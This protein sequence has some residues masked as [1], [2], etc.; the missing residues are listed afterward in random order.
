MSL[1]AALGLPP[2]PPR[3]RPAAELAAAAALAALA[4]LSI[5]PRVNRIDGAGRLQLQVSGRYADGRRADLTREVEWSS[6]NADVLSVDAAGLV[7]AR[8]VDGKAVVTA[9]DRATRLEDRLELEVRQP[10]E[11]GGL[12]P[13]L[14]RID[15][16]PEHARVQVGE[17]LAL[18]AIGAYSDEASRDI[19]GAVEWVSSAP[20]VLAFPLAEAVGTA[21]ASAPGRAEV[22]A[23]HRGSRVDSAKVTVEVEGGAAAG[24]APGSGR[25]GAARATALATALAEAL[26]ALA[27]SPSGRPVRPAAT[28]EAAADAVLAAVARGLQL[29]AAPA[30]AGDAGKLWAAAAP[31]AVALLKAAADAGVTAATLKPAHEA[32]RD[33]DTRFRPR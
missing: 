2:L 9:R 24:G 23:R 8:A 12:P 5:A 1:L 14:H 25:A 28:G 20:S 16:Q 29:L 33:L 21:H 3:A 19:T 15:V 31:K 11:I 13:D 17:R 7:V 22:Q 30:T 32:L 18:R 26:A 27:A 10:K 4:S 6:S